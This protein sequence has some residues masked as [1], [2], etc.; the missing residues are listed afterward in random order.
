MKQSK[1]MTVLPGDLLFADSLQVLH[2]RWVATQLCQEKPSPAQLLSLCLKQLTISVWPQRGL[3]WDSRDLLL[4]LR[5]VR[6]PRTSWSLC[7]QQPSLD[8]CQNPQALQRCWHQVC[9]SLSS[10]ISFGN[11]RGIGSRSVCLSTQVYSGLIRVHLRYY[12]H[13]WDTMSPG[14]PV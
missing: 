8:V 9:L 7:I 2:T 10:P 13:S 12:V 3:L 11:L 4:K 6:H 14:L 5:N 1:N